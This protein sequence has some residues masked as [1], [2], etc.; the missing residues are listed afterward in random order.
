M[1]YK[2]AYYC[3]LQNVQANFRK[4]WITWEE[5]GIRNVESS[6]QRTKVVTTLSTNLFYYYRCTFFFH[7]KLH[8]A[9]KTQGCILR[10]ARVTHERSFF[11]KF[12]L[13][14][15]RG[16]IILYHLRF[17]SLRSKANHHWNTRLYSV[18][19][20]WWNCK[21]FETN[22]IKGKISDSK[23]HSKAQ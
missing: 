8:Y 6:V 19:L 18:K 15:V 5:K 23:F 2:K 9:Q 17:F 21:F 20:F 12:L 7:N 4:K 14:V 13:F 11:S 10:Q 3:E 16:A 1:V 22:F